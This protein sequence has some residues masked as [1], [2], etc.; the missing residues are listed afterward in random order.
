M[1]LLPYNK[2]SLQLLS[3]IKMASDPHRI[4]CKLRHL[5]LDACIYVWIPIPNVENSLN[6]KPLLVPNQSPPYN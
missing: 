2:A 3:S 1:S 4:T 6:S 5:D